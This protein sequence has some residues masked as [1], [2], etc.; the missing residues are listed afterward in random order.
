MK[1]LP[2]DVAR[3]LAFNF[4]HLIYDERSLDFFTFVKVAK[5]EG[6]TI[7][8]RLSQQLSIE[9]LWRCL[10]S[11]LLEFYPIDTPERW[12][13]PNLQYLMHQLAMEESPETMA[14]VGPQVICTEKG[15]ALY[16]ECFPEDKQ[17]YLPQ[18]NRPHAVYTDEE[19][20]PF[21]RRICEVFAEC[22]V[23]WSEEP[24]FPLQF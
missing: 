11:E 12:G 1:F 4:V 2:A 15:E 6:G 10:K 19:L 21:N 16:D 13:W 3:E 20:Q 14:W 17:F 9:L 8:F 24:T 18:D 22:G 7:N 5:R 23:P